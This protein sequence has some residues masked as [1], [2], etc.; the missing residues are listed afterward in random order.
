MGVSS[1]NV[2]S[3]GELEEPAE[4]E[5]ECPPPC[6]EN[7]KASIPD[8]TVL[9]DK[10]PFFNGRTCEYSITILT[11]YEGSPE[12]V[13][14]DASILNEGVVKL[15]E[16]YGKKTEVYTV[17]NED[18]SEGERIDPIALCTAEGSVKEAFVPVRALLKTRALVV[19]P[20]DTFN[21]IEDLEP[22]EE[23]LDRLDQPGF[24]VIKGDDFFPMFNQTAKGMEILAVKQ[25]LWFWNEG[26]RISEPMFSLQNQ[27]RL[28]KVFRKN[29]L[30][31]IQLNDF[32]IK[33]PARFGKKWVDEIEIGFNEEMAIDYVR[34]LERG[35]DEPEVLKKGMSAFK[36]TSPATLP[37]IM[38]Y[39]WQLPT[40]WNAFQV[41]HEMSFGDFAETYV[42]YPPLDVQYEPDL[43]EMGA[44][45]K[46]YWCPDT[47]NS[48]DEEDSFIEGWWNDLSASVMNE[49]L[50]FPAAYADRFAKDLCATFEG[51]QK[52]EVKMSDWRELAARATDSM[53]REYFSGDAFLEKIPEFLDT[54]ATDP[55][56]LWTKFLDKLEL[57]GLL[58]LLEMALK[59]LLAG[60]DWQTARNTILAN[61]FA[62]MDNEWM[63]KIFIG[64]PPDVQAMLLESL[65]QNLANIPPP[66]DSGYRP[67]SYSGQGRTYS[68]DKENAPPGAEA[69]WQ[70]QQEITVDG[71]TAV[72]STSSDIIYSTTGIATNESAMGVYYGSPGS[73][74]TALDNVSDLY[75]AEVKK[76][77]SEMIL[78]GSLADYM[79]D[80]WDGFKASS[81][82]AADIAGFVEDFNFLDDM[83]CPPF[84]LFTPP[85]GDFWKG[86]EID[87][88]DRH[89][90]ITLPILVLPPFFLGDI[91]KLIISVAKELIKELVVKLIVLLLQKLLELIFGGLCALLGMLGAPLVN[92]LTGGNE[93]KEAMGDALCEDAT[94]ELINEALQQVMDATLSDCG[95]SP[96][97]EDAGAFVE[98][99]AAVLTNAEVMELLSGE[100]SPRVTQM[101]AEIVVSQ[102]PAF[103]CMSAEDIANLFKALGS[104]LNKDL[105]QRGAEAAEEIP[106]CDSI[107]GSPSQM[108]M[109]NEIRCLMLQSKGLTPEQCQEQID[110]LTDRAKADLADL[111]DLLANGPFSN[112]PEIVGE[113]DCPDSGLPDGMGGPI[114]PA[115]PEALNDAASN[116]AKKTFENISRAHVKDLVGNR[117][118]FDMILSDSNG[119]G[120]KQHS[121]AV[122]GLFGEP[123]AA[124]VGFFEAYTDNWASTK[125]N[126]ASSILPSGWNTD[127]AGRIEGPGSWATLWTEVGTGGYPIT[128]G[129]L[130]QKH[131]IRYN[132]SVA[133]TMDVP[134]ATDPGTTMRSL[135]IDYA[136][137]EAGLSTTGY[138]RGTKWVIEADGDGGRKMFDLNFS[139]YATEDLSYASKIEAVVATKEDGAWSREDKTQTIVYE[140]VGSS[141]VDEEV[142]SFTVTTPIPSGVQSLID[143]L[144][145]GNSNPLDTAIFRA[146]LPEVIKSYSD[147]DSSV[148]MA[149]LKD[150]LKDALP[151]LQDVYMRKFALFL[152]SNSENKVSPAPSPYQFGYSEDQQVQEV[153]MAG[154]DKDPI[155]AAANPDITDEEIYERFG[156][157]ERNP[158]FYLRNP[159]RYGWLG[160]MDKFVPPWD[161]CD[162]VDGSEPREPI[163]KFEDL[164]DVYTDLMNK[165]RDDKRLFAYPNSSCALGGAATPFNEIMTRG[166][167]A[168]I[169]TSI[170]ALIRIY[171]TEA[172]L[173]GTSIFSVFGFDC[174]GEILSRYVVNFIE[175]DIQYMGPYNL[176]SKNYYYLFMEQV[177]QM[178]GRQK[179][180]GMI[181]PTRE[182]QEALDY[183]N[184]LIASF[185]PSSHV[186]YRIQRNAVVQ[187]ALDHEAETGQPGIRT[188][189]SHFILQ[190]MR[191]MSAQ[192]EESLHA[193]GIP[194]PNIPSL[195]LQS[196]EFIH[197]ASVEGRDVWN[198]KTA[199][200]SNIY[201]LDLLNA[202]G[203]GG[204]SVLFPVYP[205]LAGGT[206]AMQA[207]V[208]NHPFRLE[209]Y[210]RLTELAGAHPDIAN[211]DEELF[212][213]VSLVEF[214]NWVA[215]QSEEVRSLSL[216]ECFASAQLGYRIVFAVSPSN[217]GNEEWGDETNAI[218]D[219]LDAA[220]SGME[221]TIMQEKTLKV[222]VNLNRYDPDSLYVPDY[223]N[224]YMYM[225]PIASAEKT[226]D[227]SDNQD[228]S[229]S[230]GEIVDGLKDFDTEERR[231]LLED[232]V[233]TDAYQM[234]FGIC[235]PF[236]KML[237]W[238][239]IYVIN[240]FLPSV[241]WGEDGWAIEGGKWM[242]FDEGFKSWDQQS[243]KRSKRAARRTFLRFYHSKDPTYE[244]EEAKD[245][246]KEE[247]DQEKDKPNKDPGIRWWKLRRKVRKPTDKN[248]VLCP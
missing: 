233:K 73:I 107:C 238:L 202:Y 225:I 193:D 61:A 77:L 45:Q 135:T 65:G 227:T 147:Y 191:T 230:L 216:S 64:L 129:S 12:E 23:Q 58:A 118:F 244:D 236:E 221:T 96:T 226:I 79:D 222:P 2:V 18:G 210:I 211:R 20:S 134:D 209:R 68:L 103:E 44:D 5:P 187:S 104:L 163:C 178:F 114:L 132:E 140:K 99:V 153:Y 220:V 6:V 10:E 70:P 75:W 245:E 80:I 32:R 27:A 124:E 87:L 85:L 235:I 169:D 181:E 154:P 229:L 175:S 90:A 228:G 122:G 127:V 247:A 15:L 84:P 67:G 37:R 146:Y 9:T 110:A 240:N 91:F 29:L 139:D 36:N 208:G 160:M 106:V 74:G 51:K 13:K 156:G 82:T 152:A 141:T 21:S 26:G 24:V 115:I 105:L 145:L 165:Y 231:C 120:L 195:F 101:L 22:S 46:P 4:E 112:F 150:A 232:L 224:M 215:A 126:S 142:Q 174:F 100:A 50:G 125:D 198:G 98:I 123:L 204:S 56:E 49:I 157:N 109:F 3:C 40:I 168:G 186:S 133:I 155:F 239:A 30:Q 176:P 16:F 111:V 161:A 149:D 162:P 223:L 217:R 128:V 237:S 172:L 8:W 48:A 69:T 218:R 213:V 102:I 113:S 66:W 203:S 14:A 59:C 164:K 35:C 57:C 159:E 173:R 242:G 63:G 86:L 39:V 33:K 241:G 42:A 177:V 179:D 47:V 119:A 207:G 183:L 214:E 97:P 185:T 200:E 19:V 43:E 131:L 88:C 189:L 94:D 190:E 148:G 184:S 130:L 144:E 72:Q 196:P 76:V 138:N 108:Q 34:V 95:T 31:L 206:D 17:I 52:N 243:F 137:D 188:L 167:A 199:S 116:A 7:P 205:S 28:L 166:G 192:F 201:E 194:V 180:I 158:P 89:L 81:G 92:A 212:G 11:E 54:A 170:M 53:L 136:P 182:E 219:N 62:N 78:G 1:E 197:G 246:Q 60:M 248:E 83:D 71:N 117:G 234:I 143:D 25:A 121:K 151:Y 38:Y 55:D 171:V 41:V 93:F